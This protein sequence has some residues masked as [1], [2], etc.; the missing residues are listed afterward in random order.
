MASRLSKSD[1]NQL[2]RLV[3]QR[4]GTTPVAQ[5]SDAELKKINAFLADKGK[6]QAL[7]ATVVE[8]LKLSASTFRQL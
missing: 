3:A 4:P 5:L 2:E 8:H 6:E 7:G 1:R